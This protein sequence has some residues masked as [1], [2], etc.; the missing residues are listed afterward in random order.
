MTCSIEGKYSGA[1]FSADT[2]LDG[3]FSHRSAISGT[4]GAFNQVGLG[5]KGARDTNVWHYRA[6]RI[7]ARRLSTNEIQ[8]L[9]SEFQPTEVLP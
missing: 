9:A 1:A 6:L 8:T 7:Y 2:Y 5:C 4:N 3:A